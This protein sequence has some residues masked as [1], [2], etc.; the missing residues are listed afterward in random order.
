MELH[1]TP[2]FESYP[3]DVPHT[4]NPKL[5]DNLPALF[6]DCCQ[7]Y[8]NR[9]AFISLNSSVTYNEVYEKTCALATYLQKVLKAKKGDRL[10]VILPNFSVCSLKMWYAGCKH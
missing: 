5:Y 1:R 3:Q 7:K 2:W 8:G 9:K 10:A 4:I 6:D